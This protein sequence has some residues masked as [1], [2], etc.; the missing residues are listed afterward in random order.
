MENDSNVYT[1]IGYTHGAKIS[2]LFYRGDTK[3]SLLNIPFI[4]L[5]KTNNFISFSY[6]NQMF[7]PYDLDQAELI[8]DD[9]PYAGYSYFE[10]GL[11]QST[12]TDL[13]SLTLQAGVIGSSSGMEDLQALFHKSIDA[14]DA[15]GWS[16]QLEDEFIVQLNYMHK[17]RFELENISDMQ[18]VL[19]P[20]AGMN[21]GNA[22]IKAS[23]GA[24]YR[25]G[26]NIPKDFGTNSMNEGSY[27]SLPT[28]SKAIVNDL[29]KWSL[30]FNLSLGSNAVAKDIFLDDWY[31][32]DRNYFNAYMSAGVTARYKSFSVDYQHNY[33]T[34]DYVQRG[35]Y[36]DYKG[37]GF[38]IL[39]YNFK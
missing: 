10:I 2:L 30:V 16:H 21:L 29:S 9:R 4:S 35:D 8:K 34:K 1:D 39:T 17:W 26:F 14:R 12:K 7:T 5:D 11:H 23:V 6:A 28:E 22:S 20:Y 33:Y 38:L 15:A 24:Q 31:E 37:Y 27:S 36:K 25:V 19:I 13:D 18:T 3:D 32:V